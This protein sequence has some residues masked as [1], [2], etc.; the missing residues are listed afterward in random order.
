[1]SDATRAE[2]LLDS[3]YDARSDAKSDA[4]SERRS[5]P[6]LPPPPVAP[7]FAGA[8]PFS[9]PSSPPKQSTGGP[10]TPSTDADTPK[11]GALANA[12]AKWVVVKDKCSNVLKTQGIAAIVVFVIVAG[13]MAAVNPPICQSKPKS[14]DEKP[15]RSVVKILVWATLAAALA[16]VIPLGIDYAKKKKAKPVSVVGHSSNVST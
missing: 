11:T 1:M 10:G 5:T 6:S 16:L 7:Q 15:K 12:K 4:R 3:R 14:P 8:L 9:L 2:K 13:I